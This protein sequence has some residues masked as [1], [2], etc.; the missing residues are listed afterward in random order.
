MRWNFHWY[1]RA[2][3]V[4]LVAV[5]P[6]I[7]SEA[8][9]VGTRRVA[10]RTAEAFSAGE[11]SGVA[12]DA[13]GKLR[14]G[15][16]LAE[17]PVADA[18]T[19]WA[20]LDLGG[21]KTLL[22]TGNEG[23]LIEYSA[24]ATRVVGESEALVL[25]SLVSAW[26][27][28]VLVS[29]LPGGKIFEYRNGK[30][31]EWVT[32][33]DEPPIYQLAYDAQQQVVYAATGG[34]GKLYRITADG[35]AQV[36]FD[37]SEQHLASVAVGPRAV[38]VGAG[39]KAKLYEVT[40]PGRSRVVHDFGLTE[41]RAVRVDANGDVFAIANEIK[42]GKS[43]PSS[44]TDS[45]KKKTSTSSGKGVLYRFE[46]G[47]IPEQ[48]LNVSDEHLVS[49]VL[50][51][52]GRPVV[53]SGEKGRV[54]TIDEQNN[55]ILLADVE[56][57]Q[58]SS[59]L[60]APSGTLVIGS[61]PAVIHP[62][63]GMG[64]AEAMWTSAV[65]DAGLRAQFGRLGFEG[66]GRVEFETRSGNTEEPDDSWGPW[67]A[68]IVAPAKI[69]S[70]PA[71]YLQIRARFSDPQAIV[72]EVH[73]A[74]V[75]DNLRA[76]ITEIEVENATSRAFSAP[77]G[78]LDSSGG[79]VTA[80]PDNEVELSWE[81]TNPDKDALRFRLWYSPLSQG[82]QWFPLTEPHE[83][84]TK[85]SYTWDTSD[86]PEGKYRV[87]IEASDEL[88]NAPS[89]VK[90]HSLES[91][92]IVVDNTAPVI[93]AVQVDGRRVSLRVTDGVGPIARLEVAVAGTDVWFPFDPSDGVFDEP[94][95]S[96]E[97]DLSGVVPAGATLLTVRAYDQESNQVVGNVFLK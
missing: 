91:H 68:P 69:S 16:D 76:V 65:L 28:R 29:A 30:L 92:V 24:G 49:L 14:A 21:G 82:A 63:R 88:A 42:S 7:A 39:D 50:D 83:K 31:S 80:K 17:V 38:Y 37:A 95:E 52:A 27:K 32:L 96:F 8:E 89:R 56:E 2:S 70:P 73:V 43:L 93:E 26:A 41:V 81:V 3:V 44:D 12:V 15:Y 84:W 86:L 23:R 47:Q 18:T 25:T 11:L 6:L 94:S 97:L 58:V 64:G 33:P 57:R 34:E 60:F 78:K 87:R 53:G 40:G 54:Y 4:S 13:T 45:S 10:I 9:A 59:I 19:V 62:L 74:F 20:T 66:D 75:T 36:Y 1:K 67:S 90:R 55:S 71:R 35:K 72:R 61:D 46:R 48:L 85:S 22:A 79:P 77:D 51:P 5:S